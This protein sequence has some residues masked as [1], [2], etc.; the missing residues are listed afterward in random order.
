MKILQCMTR[1]SD[2]V[3]VAKKKAERLSGG[4]SITKLIEMAGKKCCG[5]AYVEKLT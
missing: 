1:K 3:S 5:S 2:V 4:E